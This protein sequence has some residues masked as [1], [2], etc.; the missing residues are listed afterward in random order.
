MERIDPVNGV[1]REATWRGNLTPAEVGRLEAW[2]AAH[3]EERGV[4]EEEVALTRLLTRLPDSAAPSNLAARVLDAIDRQEPVP[5]RSLGAS[6]LGG[7]RKLGWVPRLAGVAVLVMAGYLGHH[8]YQNAQR[9]QLARNVVEV[10]ELAAAVPSVEVLQDFTA[11]RNLE[12]AAV[13]DE[14]LLALLQ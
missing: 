4:W 8:Q 13:A 2:L 7:L 5:R 9:A 12:S 6:W 11:I 3:P 10:S 14:E 1:S